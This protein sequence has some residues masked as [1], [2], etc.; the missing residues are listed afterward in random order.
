M[1]VV[2]GRSVVLAVV[3]GQPT[4]ERR[5]LAV[6][7]GRPLLLLMRFGSIGGKE[8]GLYCK[9]PRCDAWRRRATTAV[10][11]NVGMAK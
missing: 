11:A 2:S 8:T 7:A 4:I 3:A 9:E 1:P 6:L 5:A 10:G